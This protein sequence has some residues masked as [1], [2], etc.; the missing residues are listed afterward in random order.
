MI[1]NRF[2]PTIILVHGL[3]MNRAAMAFQRSRLGHCGYQ[4]L[5][6]S[7]R[8]R[9]GTLSEAA[10]GLAKFAA[11]LS[12]DTVHFV[13]HS[14][15]GIVILQMLDECPHPRTGRIV[16]LGSPCCDSYSARE[17]SKATLGRWLIGRVVSQWLQTP[18]LDAVKRYET[19]VVAGSIAFGLGRAI[20]RLP[21][22]NDGV[23][24]VHETLI[25]GISDH[26]TMRVSHSGMLLSLPV[27]NQICTFLKNGRFKHAGV[28]R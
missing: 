16:L 12:A 7:Y 27:A 20:I 3:W 18:R 6:Y 17:L 9:S 1:S 15:G 2:S 26:I 28:S 22:P 10:H 21:G 4:V 11:S 25:P 19:G 8:S 23:V 24:L 13:G 14:L 5:C